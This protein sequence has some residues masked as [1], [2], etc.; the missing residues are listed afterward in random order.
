MF[1]VAHTWSYP[2]ST[3]KSNF[4]SGGVGQAPRITWKNTC[5]GMQNFTEIKQVHIQVFPGFNGD[6]MT[7]QDQ[8][9]WIQAVQ[10]LTKWPPP[11]PHLVLNWQLTSLACKMSHYIAN[12]ELPDGYS[13]VENTM[14]PSWLSPQSNSCNLYPQLLPIKTCKLSFKYDVPSCPPS[15]SSKHISL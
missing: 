4:S 15:S 7:F 10:F 2:P 8:E 13:L 14:S 6:Q 11:M 3:E 1:V 12:F 5:M 9:V